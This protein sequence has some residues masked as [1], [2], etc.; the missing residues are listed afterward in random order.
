MV[1]K[2]GMRCI[3]KIGR[4]RFIVKFKFS[5]NIDR[6]KANCQ[7]MKAMV[8]DI[9]FDMKLGYDYT[10]EQAFTNAFYVCFNSKTRQHLALYDEAYDADL[11]DKLE[12][13]GDS[14]FSSLTNKQSVDFVKTTFVYAYGLHLVKANLQ[15]RGWLRRMGLSNEDVKF[16][17]LYL[18][19]EE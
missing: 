9:L 1:R 12:Q 11:L 3:R 6:N 4:D 8:S 14:S 2:R 10:F 16:I 18:E 17:K 19:K 15:R 5:R 7:K 13:R